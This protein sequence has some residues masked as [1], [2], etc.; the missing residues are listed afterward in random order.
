M[1]WKRTFCEKEIV[2]EEIVV[3]KNELWI[4]QNV[5][6]ERRE[7]LVHSPNQLVTIQTGKPCPLPYRTPT[8]PTIPGNHHPHQ[9]T[10]S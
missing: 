5:P 6:V 1:L 4:P 8:S 10:D 2:A 7:L 3:E 9:G